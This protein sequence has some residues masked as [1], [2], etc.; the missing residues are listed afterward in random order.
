MD[1]VSWGRNPWEETVLIRISWDL[2]WAALV[3]GILFLLAHGGYML[4]SAYRPKE[5]HE[6]DTLEKAHG[7]LPSTIERHSFVARA[8]HWVMAFSMLALVF[9][10]FLPVV[11]VRFAW[12][13]W[14]WWAGLLLTASIVFHIIHT[15]VFLDF[16]SIWVGPKD[17]PEARIELMRELGKPVPPDAPKPGKYPLGNRLYHLAVLLAGLAVI[18]T[19]LLMM[20]RVR[21]NLVPRDPYIMSDAAWGW[22]YVAHG[23]AAVSFVGLIIAHIYFALRPEHLWLTKAMIFG[24][25]SRRQYLSHHDPSRWVVAKAAGEAKEPH[26]AV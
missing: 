4:F 1:F 16:W 7:H 24:R 18:A 15:T 26:A 17:I 22:T 25:V 19:G 11:G 2:F 3:G 21:T 13:E 20:F 12:V 6:V 9:T 14:H 5:D 10:A 23:V 8:F